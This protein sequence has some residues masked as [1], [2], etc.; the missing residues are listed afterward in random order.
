M[1][2]AIGRHNQVFLGFQEWYDWS[3]HELGQHR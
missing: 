3:E 2:P 1:Q